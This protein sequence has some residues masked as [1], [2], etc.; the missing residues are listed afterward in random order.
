MIKV[1]IVGST[2]YVAGELIRCLQH[3]PKVEV[4]FLYSHSQ[5]GEL[6]G[7]IHQDLG[8]LDLQFTDQVNAEVDVLFLCLGH[9]NSKK[10]LEK[11]SFAKT[12]KI[13]DLSNDFRLNKDAVFQ[14]KEFVYGLV[15]ANKE[16]IKQAKHIANPGCF[17]TA[18]QLALLPLAKNELLKDELH[19][20]ALTGST[21][22]GQKLTETSHFSWRNQN[23]SIYKAFQH[24]HLDE[25][26]ETLKDL[27]SGFSEE[28]NF[29]PLRGDFTRGIFASVYTKSSLSQEELFQHYKTYYQDSE[30]VHVTE[31]T[32]NLKQVVNTNMAFIQVQ[33]IDGKVLITSV[34]DNLL[35]GA[36]GQAIQNMNLLFDFPENAGLQLKA[37][38]F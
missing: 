16:K 24:Q 20:H 1:G 13:I 26:G 23:V 32:I 33:K 37:N 38:Y 27:Q 21:G 6:V 2:G 3:H 7:S 12:T 29:L 5:P 8:Y 18:I 17:A 34:I 22:A 9:G 4:D 35:K 11:Y 25:I 15:E 31:E 19:I 28:I 14:E 10:F 30:F 36:A